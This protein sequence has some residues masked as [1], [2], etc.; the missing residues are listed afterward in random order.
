MA[1]S[2]E[3][4]TL[5]VEMVRVVAH[6]M[7]AVVHGGQLSQNHWSIYLIVEGGGSVRLNMAITTPSDD[8]GKFSVTRHQYTE[9]QS[10]V[11]YFDF[12]AGDS[13]TVGHVLC[14]IQDKARHRYRM[15]PT[16]V[17]CRHWV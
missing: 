10:A 17:G 11:R 16:G 9:T 2:S 7:G 15:T 6:T 14:L 5:V 8:T 4:P 13:I 1:A 3:I 12:A